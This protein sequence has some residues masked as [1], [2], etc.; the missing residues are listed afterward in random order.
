MPLLPQQASAPEAAVPGVKPDE[1]RRHRISTPDPCAA[2]ATR[3]ARSD[4]LGRQ[5]SAELDE[6][7]GD[8]VDHPAGSES[9]GEQKKPVDT[10][11]VA[12]P[13]PSMRCRSPGQRQSRASRAQC[14]R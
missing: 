4:G 10:G 3:P 7:V 9:G 14:G 5:P 6:I 2:A 1:S 13:M 12:S 8:E 11:R